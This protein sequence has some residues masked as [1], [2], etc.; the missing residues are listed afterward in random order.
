VTDQLGEQPPRSTPNGAD[1]PGADLVNVDF[2]GT[3]ALLVAAL[4]GVAAPDTF[5]VA[6]V[7][8]SGV[9]FAIGIVAFLWG[10]ANGV[11][12]SREETI[13]LGGL[14][15]LAGTAPPVVRFRMRLALAVQIV[16]A[17]AAASIRPYTA[18]AFAVLAPMF[19]LGLMAAWAARHGEFAP[20]AD[21]S[22]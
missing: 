16:A 9:L 3:G 13:T 7:A 2:A 4:A 8:V 19:G 1:A 12:R 17:V 14:F 22:R 6:T 21:G 20:K 11:V 15:F 5:D 10:Y 18:V